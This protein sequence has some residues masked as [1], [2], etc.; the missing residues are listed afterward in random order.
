MTRVRVK[1]FKIFDDRH[2]KKRCYHRKTGIALDLE[3]HPF[4]SAEFFAECARI[5]ALADRGQTAKPGTLGLLILRYRQHA[6]FTDLADRTRAD[7]QRVFDYLKPIADTQLA[8]FTPPRIVRIRDKAGEDKGRRFGTYVKQVLSTVFG[9]GVE[10]GHLATNPA[11]KIK[12]IRKPRNAPAAN[13]PWGDAERHAVMDAA[14]PHLR[15]PLA[16]MMFTGMDPQD[17]LSLPRSAITE[18]RILVRRGKTGNE[19]PIPIVSELARILADSDLPDVGPVCLNSKGQRWTRDGFHASWRK[20]RIRLER[21]GGVAPGLTPKGLRHTVA[22]ILAEM[23]EDERAIADVLGHST[24]E[25]AR[26]YSRRADKTEK[27]AGIVSRFDAEANRRRTKAV[28][29]T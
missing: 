10:R 23:G 20:L 14:P 29:P 15:L 24:S 4:G 9:W 19:S 13:R 21:D 27:L 11:F 25:M 5:A 26:H 17:A 22:T 28:K 7:Y 2:G 8:W 1:G 12:S 18:G 16:L 3:T 6:A